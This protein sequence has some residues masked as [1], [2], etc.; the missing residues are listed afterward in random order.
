MRTEVREMREEGEIRDVPHRVHP[1]QEQLGDVAVHRLHGQ[2]RAGQKVSQIS[3]LHLLSPRHLLRF[4][5]QTL[6]NV[7]FS[8]KERD[9]GSDQS[10]KSQ[11]WVQILF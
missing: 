11:I 4:L 2:P 8:C 6:V 7:T 5:L 9:Q 10:K 3:P 1:S